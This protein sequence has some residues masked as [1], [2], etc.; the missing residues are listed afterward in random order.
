MI[1]S[2]THNQ[3]LNIFFFFTESLTLEICSHNLL[4]HGHVLL[5]HS[6]MII[7]MPPCYTYVLFHFY[8]V[9]WPRNVLFF[10]CH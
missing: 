6:L 9:K 1:K 7:T 4:I 5:I 10:I 2:D 3:G 8:L